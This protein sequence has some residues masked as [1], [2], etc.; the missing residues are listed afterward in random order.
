MPVNWSD[1][2]SDLIGK[3]MQPYETVLGIFTWVLIFSA[4]I[5]YV[6]LKQ[7][8]YVAAAVAGIVILTAFA[9]TGYL[10]GAESWILMITIIISL[11]VTGLFI[12][13]I[14]KRRK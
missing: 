12:L 1:W 9:A 8:S 6:Y 7:Q 11:A 13:F 14:S 3:S 2:S 10:V 4:I 5:G